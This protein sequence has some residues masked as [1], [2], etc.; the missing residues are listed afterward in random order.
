MRNIAQLIA[1]PYNIAMNA[2]PKKTNA[3]WKLANSAVNVSFVFLLSIP[4]LLAFGFAS[5]EYKVAVVLLFLTYQLIVAFSPRK[6]DF[7]D[8]VTR[9]RWIQQYPLRNHVTFAILYS[10]SF[11]TTFIWIFFPFDL[12]L[13]N[14]L[15]IQLPIVSTTGHTL[16]G[17]LSGKMAGTRV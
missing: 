1:K 13:C 5:I 12:L 10:L 6:I 8:F 3:F 7:G 16:H 2:Q 9:T 11:A 4:L 15:L 14:L 17:Y